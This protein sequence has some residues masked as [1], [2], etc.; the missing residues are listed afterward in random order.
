MDKENARTTKVAT[1]ADTKANFT[2]TSSI[3]QRNRLLLALLQG[4]VS[5]FHARNHLN[6]LHPAARIH[7]LKLQGYE[8][9]SFRIPLFDDYGRPHRR[10]ALYV[11]V[12]GIARSRPT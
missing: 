7:E 3:A 12:H 2:D 6:I 1:S 4:P 9:Q 8:I 10:M 5:T 11:L